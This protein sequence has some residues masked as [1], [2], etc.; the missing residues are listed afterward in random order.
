MENEIWKMCHESKRKIYEV[1]NMGKIRSIYKNTKKEINLIPQ[2]STNGY[3]IVQLRPCRTIHSLVANSFLG[4]KPEGYQIDH[5][6]RCKT[7]NLLENLRYCTP[8]ENMQNR[9]D[10][11]H[12]ILETDFK[13]RKNII[14]LESYH[15][16]KEK[17]NERRKEKR[18]EK[19]LSLSK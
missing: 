9:S 2:M 10:Y 4:T 17:E 6:D 12:D 11:R 19:K 7:N 5:I 3:L 8:L 15:R 14:R 16:N 13:T 1:S 18:K